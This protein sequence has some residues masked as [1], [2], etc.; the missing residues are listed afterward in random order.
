ML[1]KSRKR[2][3]LTQAALAKLSGVPQAT[4]CDIE[5]GQD[6]S[7][8]KAIKIVKALKKKGIKCSVESV[9]GDK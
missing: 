1:K 2:A 4:I 6:P 9:F 7:V 8:S 3:K 5:K